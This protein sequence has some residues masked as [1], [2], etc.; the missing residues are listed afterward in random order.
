[1]CQSLVFFYDFQFNDLKNGPSVYKPMI[2]QVADSQSGIWF[3]PSGCF[4]GY[5]GLIDSMLSNALLLS[6]KLAIADANACSGISNETP[7]SL[8]P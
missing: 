2:K 5:C 1:M 4:G 7:S 8:T 6:S 3:V